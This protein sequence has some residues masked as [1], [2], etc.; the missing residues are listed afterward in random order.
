M[1]YEYI[2]DVGEQR[3]V[4][5]LEKAIESDVSGGTEQILSRAREFEKYLRGDDDAEPSGPKVSIT[6]NQ[7]KEAW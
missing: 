7:R 3:R 5:A 4:H 6:V 1:T 2:N